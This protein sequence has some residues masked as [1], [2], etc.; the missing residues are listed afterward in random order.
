MLCTDLSIA[1]RQAGMERGSGTRSGLLWEV[2]RLLKECKE[3][4]DKDSRYGM[5]K[6]LVCEN[7]PEIKGYKNIKH[8]EEWLSF[9]ES[10]GY[11]N[12]HQVLNA[13]DYGCAQHRERYFCVSLFGDYNYKF[14]TSIPLNT[15]MADYLDDEVDEKYYIKSKKAYDLIMKLIDDGTLENG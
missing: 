10:L 12:Y 4:A 2:E 8:L 14:P 13:A 15:V 1:G 6:V 7:V 9:L 3:L 5:P 11:T